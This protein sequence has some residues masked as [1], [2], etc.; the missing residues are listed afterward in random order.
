MRALLLGLTVLTLCIAACSQSSTGDLGSGCQKDTDCKGDRVCDNGRCGP[1]ST[2]NA[3]RVA[4]PA[5]SATITADPIP[6]AS[7]VTSSA[8]SHAHAASAP[9]TG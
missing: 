3:A 9:E 5:S 8:P 7:P 6:S 2:T 1:P 4:P